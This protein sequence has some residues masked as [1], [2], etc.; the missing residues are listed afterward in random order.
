MIAINRSVTLTE[1]LPVSSSIAVYPRPQGFVLGPL[2]FEAYIEDIVEILDQHDMWS[3]LYADDTQLYTSCQP[4]DIAVIRSRL[5]DNITDVVVRSVVRFSS[6]TVEHRKDGLHL[7]WI[8]CKP[9][10][11]RRSGLLHSRRF[12][13]DS[14]FNCRAYS[15][16]IH[17][18]GALDEAARRQ[19]SCDMLLSSTS[20]MPDSS[21]CR[22]RGNNATCTCFH[23]ITARL[24]QLRFG[25]RSS[26]HT[27]AIATSSKRCSQADFS[28]G[29]GEHV[30]QGLL[31]LHWLPVRWRIQFKLCTLMHSIYMTRCPAYLTNIVEAVANSSSRSGLRSSTIKHPLNHTTAAYQVR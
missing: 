30:T 8:S 28:I 1:C 3:H 25:W 12:R 23:H 5:S 26:D 2:E 31:Q 18:R 13:N 19:N 16:R 22:C 4:K 29:T 24:L 17:R 15:R 7:I 9:K 6:A 10:E 20:S 11:T 14:A 21:T 27:R